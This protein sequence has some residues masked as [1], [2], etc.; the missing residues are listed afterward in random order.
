[1]GARGESPSPFSA[2]LVLVLSD[3]FGLQLTLRSIKD[4]LRCLPSS[5]G[6]RAPWEVTLAHDRQTGVSTP[7]ECACVHAQMLRGGACLSWERASVGDIS[8]ITIATTAAAYP[9]R[10]ATAAVFVHANGHWNTW[11][12]TCC[13]HYDQIKNAIDHD[14]DNRHC[15]QLLQWDIVSCFTAGWR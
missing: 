10:L 6:H 9:W 1:L 11:T 7:S 8:A 3:Q 5:T 15:R 2:Q 14:G 4:A 12:C 13:S